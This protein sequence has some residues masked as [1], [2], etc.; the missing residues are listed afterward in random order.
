MS[1]GGRVRI[2]SIFADYEQYVGKVIRVAGWVKNIRA[3]SKELVFVELNDGSGFKC[4]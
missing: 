2:Q 3:Q 1:F 4:L